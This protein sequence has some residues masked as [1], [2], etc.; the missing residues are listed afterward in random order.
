[1]DVDKASMILCA[2]V[3]FLVDW[4]RKLIAKVAEFFCIHFEFVF[5]SVRKLE[6][7]SCF[8]GVSFAPAAAMDANTV[9]GSYGDDVS[10]QRALNVPVD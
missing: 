10:R 5:A 8:S 9:A 4:P 7:I 3:C 6:L 2:Y 1:M